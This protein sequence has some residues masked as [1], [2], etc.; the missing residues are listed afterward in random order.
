MYYFIE[1]HSG[2][3]CICIGGV[4]IAAAEITPGGSNENVWKPCPSSFSLYGVKDF[5]DDHGSVRIV[6]CLIKPSG[7]ED[8]VL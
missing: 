7:V 5:I 1:D 8:I 6:F 4:A 3:L 2:S